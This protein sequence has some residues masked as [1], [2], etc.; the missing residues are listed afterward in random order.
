M[1]GTAVTSSQHTCTQQTASDSLLMSAGRAARVRLVSVIRESSN[2]QSAM[3]DNLNAITLLLLLG[4]LCIDVTAGRH[5]R[6]GLCGMHMSCIT[7]LGIWS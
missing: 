5:N 3:R 1:L 7:E 4:C 2:C 6:G